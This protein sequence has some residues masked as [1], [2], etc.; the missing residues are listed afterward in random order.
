MRTREVAKIVGMNQ[1]LMQ[2][3]VDAMIVQPIAGGGRGRSWEYDER[4]LSEFR[5]IK[6][7][8]DCG[9]TLGK[10]RKIMKYGANDLY[11][12]EKKADTFHSLFCVLTGENE[13]R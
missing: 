4:G 7:L 5:I 11:Q 9:I 6:Q 13:T 1:R 10:I 2:F 8:A 3:Y 12:L